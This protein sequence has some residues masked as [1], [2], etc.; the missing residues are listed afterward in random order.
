MVFSDVLSSSCEI[1]DMW[2]DAWFTSSLPSFRD[3]KWNGE[4]HEDY[5]PTFPSIEIVDIPPANITIKNG[6]FV[7]VKR[8]KNPKWA[9]FSCPCGCGHIVTLA[10]STDKFPHWI[11]KSWKGRPTITPSVRVLTGCHSHFWVWRGQ[12]F[13]CN[14]LE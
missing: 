2:F 9:M 6:Q 3:T 13:W 7:I 4:R 12:V 1:N 8:K 10:L 11:V 5:T 14:D